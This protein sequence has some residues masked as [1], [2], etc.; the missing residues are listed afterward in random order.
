MK[1]LMISSPF[2]ICGHR[3]YPAKYPENTLISYE[4]AVKTGVAMIETDIAVSADGVLMIC[5]DAT[6]DRISD[7]HGPVSDYTCSELK[8]FNMGAKLPDCPKQ[9]MMTLEEFLIW[10]RQYP[11]ML[12]NIDLKHFGA[13]VARRAAELADFYGVTHRCVFNGLNGEGLAVIHGLGLYTEVAPEGKYTMENFDALRDGDDYRF[14]CVCIRWS[15]VNP[16]YVEQLKKTYH[17]SD[18]WC[19]GIDDEE[20]TRNAIASGIS[21]VLCN[22]PFAAFRVAEEKGLR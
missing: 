5:H 3:G 19:W 10:A 12:L 15:D 17:V 18:V 1:K 21:L 11:D 13:D 14:D 4:E 16:E 8:Q 7:G 6:L 22:D 2:I 9:R 20:R